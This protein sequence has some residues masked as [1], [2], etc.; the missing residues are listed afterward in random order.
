MLVDLLLN[1]VAIVDQL[2]DQGIDLLQAQ[3]CS[4]FLDAHRWIAG[5]AGASSQAVLLLKTLAISAESITPRAVVNVP[6]GLSVGRFWV[7]KPLN[8][9]VLF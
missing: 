3:G 2:T 6:E 9:S 4:Q 1:E 8:L 5:C 7:A